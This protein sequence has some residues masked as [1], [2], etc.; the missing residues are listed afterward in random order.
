MNFLSFGDRKSYKG[1]LGAEIL[2]RCEKAVA[3]TDGVPNRLSLPTL[4][5]KRT[6][7]MS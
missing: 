6:H 7:L 5:P 4:F 3:D 2:L 1:E